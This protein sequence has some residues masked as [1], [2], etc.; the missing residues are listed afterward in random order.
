MGHYLSVYDSNQQRVGLLR[1]GSNG[2]GS[3]LVEQWIA[4]YAISLRAD[5]KEARNVRRHWLQS[6]PRTSLGF[7]PPCVHD[8]GSRDGLI[9]ALQ[10]DTDGCSW[11]RCQGL[12]RKRTHDI[13]CPKLRA[14]VGLWHMVETFCDWD[15]MVRVSADLLEAV[16]MSTAVL[17]EIGAPWAMICRE[18]ADLIRQV[19]CSGRISLG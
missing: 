11:I 2:T 10:D 4:G 18:A 1:V 16:E 15:P 19:D 7:A 9:L 13:S 5:A 14:L 8:L 3:F 6:I 12:D 17:E